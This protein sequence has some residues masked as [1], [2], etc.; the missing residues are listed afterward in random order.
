MKD[1][2]ML[3]PAEVG[4]YTDLRQRAPRDECRLDAPRQPA[5][6]NYK[7]IPIGYHGA[8]EFAGR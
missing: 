1:A 3:F 7:H 5:T 6:P 8:R 4:D 2:E